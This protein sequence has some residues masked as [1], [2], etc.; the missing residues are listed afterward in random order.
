MNKIASLVLLCVLCK[1]ADAQTVIAGQD[2]RNERT[3]GVEPRASLR[4]N[5]T[6]GV[7][8]V[9]SSATAFSNSPLSVDINGNL[10]I[11]ANPAPDS[12]NGGLT[13]VGTFAR[14]NIVEIHNNYAVGIDLYTHSDEEFRAPYFNLYKS[15]GTQTAPTPVMFTGYEL[16]SIGGIN[17]GGWDGSKYFAGSAAIYTQT[18][19]N[20]DDTHHGGHISIYGTDPGGNTQQIAQFGGVDPNNNPVAGNII[21]YRPLTWGNNSD[22]RPGLFPGGASSP[23][24]LHVRAADDSVDGILTAGALVETIT[25]TPSSSSDTGTTGQIAWDSSYVYVCV[26][27]NTWKRAAISSW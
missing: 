11:G 1:L 15:R 17:F 3:V 5:P 14:S 18:D 25:H 16:D 27:T 13:M 23:P 24:V 8:P 26:A 2:Q 4:I 22:S 21:L 12:A 19:E 9:R 7:V 20:W 6:N 10:E